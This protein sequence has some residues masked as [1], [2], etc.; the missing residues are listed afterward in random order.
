MTI[1]VKGKEYPIRPTMWALLQFRRDKQKAVSEL[2]D[3]DLEDLLYWTYLCVK[4]TCR[5]DGVAFDIS[6]EDYCEYVE[7]SPMEVLVLSKAE[8]VK[9][10]MGSP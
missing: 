5:Q 10:K 1:K 8:D 6:F 7:G 9:K 2:K 3:E 4:N